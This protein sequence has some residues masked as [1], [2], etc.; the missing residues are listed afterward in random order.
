MFQIYHS[1]PLPKIQK[2]R[3]PK[4]AT[5]KVIRILITPIII[6]FGGL[7]IQLG[8]HDFASSL[9]NEFAFFGILLNFY[10]P[11]NY[12]PKFTKNDNKIKNQLNFR[13]FIG[14]FTYFTQ[15][16]LILQFA[17]VPSIILFFAAV[18]LTQL[19]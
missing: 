13:A 2:N 7:A 1:L 12:I 16:N 3:T 6:N 18:T 17:N 5:T 10:H 4:R 14:I 11:P 8:T 19:N 15:E 9:R